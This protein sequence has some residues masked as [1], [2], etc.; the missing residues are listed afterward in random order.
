MSS[1]LCPFPFLKAHFAEPCF[2]IWH[3]FGFISEVSASI[4]WRSISTWISPNK[5]HN[6]NSKF[7]CLYVSICVYMRLYVSEWYF[8]S[9]CVYMCL[10]VS[11]CVLLLVYSSGR[12]LY[13][14]LRPNWSHF[15]SRNINLWV[16]KWFYVSI[17]VYMCLYASICGLLLVYAS[18]HQLY[19]SLRPNWSSFC[20]QKQSNT[21]LTQVIN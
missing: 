20:L 13:W 6:D 19:W 4:V 18:G 7:M 12:Q 3:V 5:S 21:L 9:I 14:S 8:V 17:C 1:H 11:I 15:V 10:Y 2:R 16:L